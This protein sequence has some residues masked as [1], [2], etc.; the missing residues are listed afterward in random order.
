MLNN[1]RGRFI[2]KSVLDSAGNVGKVDVRNK[3]N[4]VPPERVDIGFAAKQAVDEVVKDRKASQLQVFEFYQG[5]IAIWQNM[6]E[7]LLERCLWRK[8]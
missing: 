2:K 5:C 6:T 7:K 3:E 8:E 4:I 1:L